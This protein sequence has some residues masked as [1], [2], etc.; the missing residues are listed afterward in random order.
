MNWLHGVPTSRSDKDPAKLHF[1]GGWM[2][3][4]ANVAVLS[5]GTVY[6]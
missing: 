6:S 3:Q 5:Q 2:R 1:I 4:T